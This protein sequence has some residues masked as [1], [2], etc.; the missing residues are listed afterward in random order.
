MEVVRQRSSTYL[1]APEGLANDPSAETIGKSP[2]NGGAV[3]LK[4]VLPTIS[5]DEDDEYDDDNFDNAP[6]ES[7]LENLYRI[8]DINIEDRYKLSDIQSSNFPNLN[9]WKPSDGSGDGTNGEIDA[10]SF[11]QLILYAT[12]PTLPNVT[13]IKK[14]LLTSPSFVQPT[15]LLAA[16][17]TRYYTD[18]KSPTSNIHSPEE[19][20]NIRLKVV[21]LLAQWIKTLPYQF[22]EKMIDAYN[23]FMEYVKSEETVFRVLNGAYNIYKGLSVKEKTKLVK[24]PSLL[25]PTPPDEWTL[26]DIE[27]LELARQI[28]IAQSKIFRIIGPMELLTGIWG[29]TKGG[30][31]PNVDRL[32]ANFDKLSAYVPFS[33]MNNPDPKVRGK[34]YIRWAEVAAHCY[35]LKNFNGMFAVIVGLSHRCVR[36]MPQTMKYAQKASKDKKAILEEMF[37]ICELS[38]D[39]KNYRPLYEATSDTCVP[40]I[41]CLQKDLVYIQECFPNQIGDLINWKKSIA[42]FDLISKVG[43]RQLNRYPLKKSPRIQQLIDEIPPPMDTIGLM[44]MSLRVEPPKN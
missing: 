18:I 17:F 31:S 15:R 41:G 36:R 3:S 7:P 30:G 40:F 8:L 29:T 37:N 33:I 26:D 4:G 42:C 27:P 16:L 20:K 1:I 43:L 2:I 24:M 39:Y 12:S 19:L 21:N 35:E 6:V 32:I 34:L 14:F 25:P 13:F 38:N 23:D 44:T 9:E 10:A 28:T 5:D 11:T 22:S